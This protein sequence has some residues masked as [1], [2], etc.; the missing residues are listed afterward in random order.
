[1]VEEH[2]LA[3]YIRDLQSQKAD[4]E[5][6]E[7][8]QTNE[9]PHLAEMEEDFHFLEESGALNQFQVAAQIMQRLWPDI[10]LIA[11]VPVADRFET[12]DLRMTWGQTV[13][14]IFT[15]TLTMEDISRNSARETLFY[16]G[17]DEELFQPDG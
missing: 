4:W 14:G 6:V 3:R 15:G 8:K 13:R 9:Q 16:E 5:I 2:P 11:A 10:M 17:R 1:M 12:M 7:G